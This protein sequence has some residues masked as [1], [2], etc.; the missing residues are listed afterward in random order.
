MTTTFCCHRHYINTLFHW[1]VSGS[2]GSSMFS[3][4]DT[5]ESLRISSA[6]GLFDLCSKAI[7]FWSLSLV[8]D[9]CFS[10]LYCPSL[11]I[12]FSWS[13][14]MMPSS[15][16]ELSLLD[17]KQLMRRMLSDKH[18]LFSLPLSVSKHKYNYT[19]AI[20]IES[21]HNNYLCP[22]RPLFKLKGR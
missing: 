7:R 16:P 22:C 14:L 3:S 20:D 8:K 18:V 6:C 2:L 13:F 1:P 10:S 9:F 11:I 19:N 17:I 4:Q 12:W 5:S 15:L 21:R